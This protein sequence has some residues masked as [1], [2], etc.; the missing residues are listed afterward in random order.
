MLGAL[1]RPNGSAREHP[2]VMVLV[3]YPLMHHSKV[4]LV[5]MA[6]DTPGHPAPYT[7]PRT[8]TRAIRD[9]GLLLARVDLVDDAVTREVVLLVFQN[10]RQV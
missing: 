7:L 10:G 4:L 6:T 5:A 8:T 1:T 9:A 2:L 3:L